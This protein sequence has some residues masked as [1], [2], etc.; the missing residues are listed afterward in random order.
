M[1]DKVLSTSLLKIKEVKTLQ[2][3]EVET[4]FMYK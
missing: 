3:R 2:K 4:D 1:F